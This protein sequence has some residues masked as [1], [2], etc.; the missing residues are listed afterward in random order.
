MFLAQIAA[1]INTALK[2][3]EGVK[4]VLENMSKQGGT[5]GGDF[6]ELRQIIDKVEDKSRIGVCIDTCHAMAAGYD[7]STDDGY[8]SMKKDIGDVIG[9]KYLV[10]LHLNDSKGV[11][12]C[13]L[14][15]HENL[16]KGKIGLECFRKIMKDPLFKDIPLILE[17]PVDTDDIYAKEIKI[18]KGLEKK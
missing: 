6:A 3:T 1:E 18:L 16:G 2:S 7:L 9:F 17:T 11:A 5:I 15:R 14:D 4:V 12:G 8:D 10:A 13:H